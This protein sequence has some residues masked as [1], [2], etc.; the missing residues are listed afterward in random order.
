MSSRASPSRALHLWLVMAW[1]G[2]S[3]K[4]AEACEHRLWECE[5]QAI[6]M[7]PCLECSPVETRRQNAWHPKNE[8]LYVKRAA[9]SSTTVAFG[10]ARHCGVPRLREICDN[11]RSASP[12][13]GWRNALLSLMA[14]V[15]RAKRRRIC[16]R[17]D[18]LKRLWRAF[19]CD[20]KA[21]CAQWSTP[22]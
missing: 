19:S 3:S 13:R 14:S 7:R 20:E 10:A 21:L 11:Q 1:P 12:A 5:H 2:I 15:L 4:R 17:L 9:V 22:E 8:M 18:M 6:I 16:A